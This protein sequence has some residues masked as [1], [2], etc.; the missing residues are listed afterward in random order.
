MTFFSL[1]CLQPESTFGRALSAGSHQRGCQH[2]RGSGEEGRSAQAT[3]HTKATI[4]TAPGS[5]IT[6]GGSPSPSRPSCC[7]QRALERA[8]VP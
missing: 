2:F 7:L 4:P 3:N 5:P 8:R 1:P 6:W